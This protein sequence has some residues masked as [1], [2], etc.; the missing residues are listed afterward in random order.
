MG[1]HYE[2]IVHAWERRGL[3]PQSDY[4]RWWAQAG[5][6]L[7]VGGGAEEAGSETEDGGEGEVKMGPRRDI[8]TERKSIT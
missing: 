7:E 1:H 6:Y 5:N 8:G 4:H 3:R 2:V